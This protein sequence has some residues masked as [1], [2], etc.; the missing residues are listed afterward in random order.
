MATTFITQFKNLPVGAI[1]T[2]TI[3]GKRERI[4][5]TEWF[6]SGSHA[7]NARKLEGRKGQCFVWSDSLVTVESMPESRDVMPFVLRNRREAVQ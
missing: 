5:K 6:K 1:G 4:V 3:K 7:L 2:V